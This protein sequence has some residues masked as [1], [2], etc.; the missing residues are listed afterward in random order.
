MKSLAAIVYALGLLLAAYLVFRVI[1]RRDYLR[2]G[3]L[4]LVSTALESLIWGPFFAFPYFFNQPGALVSE[5]LD[6]TGWALIVVGVGAVVLAMGSLGFRR[7][8]G[9]EVNS[10]RTA[11]LYRVTRNPQ[12][13]LGF[14]I[15]LGVIVRRPSW[16]T[17][18]WVLLYGVMAHL[19]VM[20]EEEHLRDVFGGTY[21]E[22]CRRVPRYLWLRRPVNDSGV[23]EAGS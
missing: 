7:S 19:M 8:C 21:D 5:I 11:G 22:Y 6:Y 14:L 1:A 3:K 16:Y 2:R 13:V 4:G 15:V 17:V 23:S 20:T 9:Q 18:A 10:L 12:I